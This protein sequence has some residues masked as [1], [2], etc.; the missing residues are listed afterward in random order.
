M[1]TF[2]TKVGWWYWGIIA[3]FSCI[4]FVCFW[5]HELLLTLLVAIIVIFLIEALIHTQ[6]VITSEGK[7]VI[8]SGRFFKQTSFD[9]SLI[10]SIEK[11]KSLESAPAYSLDRLK[12]IYQ[13]KA[14]K[15]YI[16]ISPQN[17]EAFIQALLKQNVSIKVS[18]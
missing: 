4:L 3:L 13:G 16:L 17:Q 5:F 14:Y 11:S 9:I 10:V 12:I 15:K 6:Y 18:I 8:E 7:L 2:H 1:R